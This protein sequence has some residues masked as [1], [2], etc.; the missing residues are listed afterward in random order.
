MTRVQGRETPDIFV[1]SLWVRNLP[2]GPGV[3]HSAIQGSIW[4]CEGET[5]PV[6]DDKNPGGV[7]PSSGGPPRCSPERHGP[8]RPGAL[9]Q[10][11]A[12]HTGPGTRGS[13]RKAC[14]HTQTTA[15]ITS[16]HLGGIWGAGGS[17]VFQ[18]FFF[19]H[20]LWPC[21]IERDSLSPGLHPHLSQASSTPLAVD[22]TKPP[23][24]AQTASE[25]LWKAVCPS[26]RAGRSWS[27]GLVPPTLGT[28]EDRVAALDSRGL[29]GLSTHPATEGRRA[30]RVPQG[31]TAPGHVTAPAKAAGRP[32]RP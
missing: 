14:P 23:G 27:G 28:P 25:C 12:H 29:A 24:W 16:G 4:L 7:G 3:S 20:S 19:R 18:V 11:P 9:P 6:L 22:P 5:R 26:L 32:R 1:P 30:L 2:R 8:Q 17:I 13:T 15:P 31:G 10:E 21:F